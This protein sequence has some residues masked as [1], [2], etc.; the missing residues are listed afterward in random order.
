M[1]TIAYTV[2]LITTEISFTDLGVGSN[3]RMELASHGS[4]KFILPLP[5]T[6]PETAFAIPFEA[7]CVI[8]TGRTFSLGSWGGGSKIFQGRRTDNS[9]QV[10]GDR[11]SCEVVIEDA[12]YDLRFLTMQSLWEII[13]GGTIT[14]PTFTPEFYPDCV[15]FQA[16]VAGMLL[17]NGTFTAYSPGPFNNHITSGQVIREILAYAIFYGGANLQI[18]TIDPAIYVPFYPIRSMRVAD[19]LKVCLRVHPDCTTEIDYTTTPP[20]FNIRQR[21]N[22]TAVT[23]P[24]KGTASNRTHLTSSVKPRPELVPSRVAIYYKET[25]TFAG[26]SVVSISSDVY[27]GGATALRSLDASCDITGPKFCTTT[28]KITAVAFDPTDITWWPKKLPAL[29]QISDGGQIP[30]QPGVGSLHGIDAAINGGSGHPKGIQVVDSTGAAINLSIYPNELVNGTVCDWMQTG[31]ILT[32]VIEA[33]V[34]AFFNYHKIS[35]VGSVPTAI[36]DTVLEQ[37]QSVRIKLTNSPVGVT[38]YTLTQQLASGETFTNGL[39][40]SIYTALA[41]LQYNFTH[42]VLEAPFATVIKPGLNALNLSGG[43]TAW[44]TMIA[45]VQETSIEFMFSP[46][47]GITSAKTTV[48]CGPV[49]HL[50]AG[51]L[52]QLLNLFTNRDFSKINPNERASGFNA[53][54]GSAAFGSDSVKENSSPAPVIPTSSNLVSVDGS[55][56]ING[57]ATFDTSVIPTN[58]AGLTIVQTE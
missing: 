41:T 15:L 2:G 14:S 58:V 13:G 22:L 17:P 52:V 11:V 36:T 31:G 16:T 9:G 45:M 34:I 53:S 8:W 26:A 19:A 54:G 44:S 27:P 49:A 5:G 35:N 29:K 1:E 47:A 18:G 32:N 23:L 55:N 30:N 57:T 6:A 51:E 21:S 46:S 42:T 7:Q 39:A 37:A 28:A 10:G 4:S 12:W 24:Y 48:R 56:V 3:P 50:E 43:A 25:S 38:T 40:Q 33:T 20:T